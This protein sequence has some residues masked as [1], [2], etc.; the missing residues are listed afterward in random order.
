MNT[1]SAPNSSPAITP[2]T[3]VPSRPKRRM[4]R[5][6]VHPKS[7]RVA[8]AER[9]AAWVTGEMPSKAVLVATWL[10]PQTRHSSTMTAI[11]AASS[12]LR[13]ES[14]L[15]FPREKAL[16]RRAILA[17]ILTRS[18]LTLLFSWLSILSWM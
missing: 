13:A 16:Q 15:V 17:E 8:T 9:I 18:R 1:N 6:R 12:G 11:P 2:G 5:S 7:R 10:R 4:P 3:S 14:N